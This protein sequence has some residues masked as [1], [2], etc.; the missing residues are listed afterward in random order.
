[1]SYT[2]ATNFAVKD[3]LPTADPN[4]VVR[5]TEIDTEFNALQTATGLLAPKANPTFTG[6][7]TAGAGAFTTLSA[8]TSV[9]TPSLTNAGTLALSATGANVLTAATNGSERL[10]VDSDGNVGIG[11]ND[12][13]GYKLRLLN[14]DT[15]LLVESDSAVDNDFAI[16]NV[17]A[18]GQSSGGV[19]MATNT[20][21]TGYP[22]N[23]VGLLASEAIPLWF[24][25]NDL[26]RI[27]IT[28]AGNVGIGTTSPSQVLHVVGTG[29][30]S[31]SVSTPTV[32]NAGTLTVSA[33]G[34]NDIAFRTNNAERARFLS[35]G[36]LRIGASGTAS[37]DVH[38][39]NTDTQFALQSTAAAG[40]IAR[41]GSGDN[42][43]NGFV[44]STTNHGFSIVTNNLRRIDVNNAGAIQF[45]AYSAGTLSTDGSG[46]VLSSD[47]RFKTKTASLEDGLSK[48]LALVPT[49]YSWNEDS[50][51]DTDTVE[52]GFIAQEVAAVIP[53]AAPE[54]QEGK[55]HN[56]HDRAIIAVLVKA[57]QELTQRVVELEASN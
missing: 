57:V 20:N 22:A 26:E 19:L 30:F 54:P 34:A 56:F 12:P 14:S 21:Q 17:K 5:G 51:F 39:F 27:R 35:T 29:L 50:G 10:R 40:R 47:G 37:A 45:V 18:S 52:L 32:T 44:G 24:G 36:Q 31:T 41:I 49:Y 25:T 43:D 8:S 13:D 7:L 38:A 4:K 15:R 48:V 9:T 23:A 1:M 42:T 28:S 55:K 6:T 16:V 3:T 46:N 2:K 33:T 11:T 53:E